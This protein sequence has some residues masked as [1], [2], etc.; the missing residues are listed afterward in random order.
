MNLKQVTI[1]A[2]LVAV[3]G[4][5]YFLVN[6]KREKAINKEEVIKIGERAIDDFD[7]SQVTKLTIQKT[8]QEVS[9]TRDG[10]NWAIAE[11]D[12]YAAN[13]NKMLNAEWKYRILK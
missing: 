5:V 9:L 1:L 3:V 2:I 12:G 11:R 4:G 13:A 8:G 7:V 10:E 6:Q